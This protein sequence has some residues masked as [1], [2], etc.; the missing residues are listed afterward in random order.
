MTELRFDDITP[1]EELVTIGENKYTLRETSGDAAIKYDNA[2]M[3]CYHYVEGKLSSV[4]NLS[5]TEPLLVS[6][7]LF[8]SEGKNVPEA[9]I[10][11]WPNRIQTAIYERAKEISGLNAPPEDLE[12]QIE[13]L[14][15]LLKKRQERKDAVKNS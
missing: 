2:K 8:D 4:K 12:N 3:T 1:I 14:Q 6:L 11:S 15:I 10:R 9:T 13:E 7:C 5:E